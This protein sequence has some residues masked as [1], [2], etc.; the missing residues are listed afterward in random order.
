MLLYTLQRFLTD[1]RAFLPGTGDPSGG[2]LAD[3][4]VE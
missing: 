3:E 1:V 2:T 4:E